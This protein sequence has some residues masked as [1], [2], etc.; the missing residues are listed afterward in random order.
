MPELQEEALLPLSTNRSALRAPAN[1]APELAVIVPT[2]NERTNI[3]EL[4][5]RLCAVLE[6][7]AFE[8]VVVDDDSPDGTAEL[9]RELAAQ[10]PRLRC[11]VRIG[12]RGLAS[13]CIEG[14][15]STSAPYLAVID[16]DLQHDERLL[17]QM[18]EILRSGQADLVVASRYL[19][20]PEVAG[21]AEERR[22]LSRVGTVLARMWP[23]LRTL[24]DPLSGFFAITRTAF[25]AT[26]RRL[27]GLGFKLLLDILLSAPVPLRIKE[28]P[29]RFSPRQWGASKLDARV[30]VEFVLLLIDKIL[31]GRIPPRFVLF[32]A[33]GGLGVL[34]H[35]G[36]LVI[37]HE[38]LAVAFL[39]AHTLA[40]FVAMTFNF[41]VNN[42][43]TYRDRRL[44]GVA[45]LRGW[46]SFLFICSLGALANVGIAAV[47]F[48][49]GESWPV[50]A[51]AGILVGAVW[52]YAVTSVF[53]WGDRSTP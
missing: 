30:A 17:L 32:A 22:L 39:R 34:V 11:L 7:V 51:L 36:T 15:L 1:R 31:G 23:R 46:L 44:R 52:N 37:L 38:Y 41:A 5:R 49:R 47:V 24:H 4:L 10:D 8:I 19:E 35:L 18:L 6:G 50:A 16:A 45:W 20:G 9:V 21:W 13:A 25:E 40:T 42:A 43:L 14:M 12:R 33:V 2:F 53:T 27:S 3:G 48:A 26:A 28:L 29:Y